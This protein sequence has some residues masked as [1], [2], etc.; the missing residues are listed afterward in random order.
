MPRALPP[1][2]IRW[3]FAAGFALLLLIQ[4]PTRAEDKP[5]RRQGAKTPVAKTQKRRKSIEERTKI[6]RLSTS[7]RAAYD[8]FVYVNR[9]PERAEEGESAEDVAGRIFGRLENQE[10]RVLLKLPGGMNRQ[11][12]LGFKTFL[13][14]EGKAKVGNCAACHAPAEFTDLKTHVVTKGGS[15][16]PTPSLRNLKKRKV[17]ITKVILNKIAASRQ[18]RSGEADEIDDAYAKM[19]LSKQD[20]P[21]LVAYLNLLNDVSDSE[22]RKLILKARLLD[23]SKDIE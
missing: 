19:N 16:K 11:S 12:Y 15:P 22:F 23:T 20:V 13:R 17:D 5:V 4:L 9:I 14:Y 10:G 21:G 8:A 18:K 6:H 2:G 3:F 1:R 7:K